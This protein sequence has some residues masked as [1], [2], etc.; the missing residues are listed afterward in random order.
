MAERRALQGLGGMCYDWG[1]T[2]LKFAH[3]TRSIASR[4]GGFC[5]AREYSMRTSP[6]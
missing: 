5:V 4:Q 3:E 1:T 6:A 2:Q